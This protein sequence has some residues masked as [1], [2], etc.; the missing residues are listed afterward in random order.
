MATE[1]IGDCGGKADLE[2]NKE[3]AN[4]KQE[5]AYFPCVVPRETEDT[6][7]DIHLSH[8]VLE[9]SNI[10]LSG[11]SFFPL[12]QGSQTVL[13]LLIHVSLICRDVMVF[14]CVQTKVITQVLLLNKQV[15]VCGFDWHT[16]RIEKSAFRREKTD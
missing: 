7:T 13:H 3:A 10:L 5:G 4:E 12:V 11:N 1:Y 9:F 15:C 6:Q 8:E 2:E 16:Y 14:L